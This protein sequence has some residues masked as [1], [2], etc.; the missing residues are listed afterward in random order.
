MEVFAEP[1]QFERRLQPVGLAIGVFDGVHR[2]HQALLGAMVQRARELQALPLVLTFDPHPNAVVRPDRNPPMI[3][4]L[5]QRLECLEA[6]GVEA[7][8]VAR[9]DRAFSLQQAEDFVRSLHGWFPQLRTLFVG[10]R[11]TFGHRRGGDTTLLRRLGG[12]LGFEVHPVQ[13]VQLE[14]A[15]VSS[16]RIRRLIQAGELA[17]AARLLGRPWR[18]AGQVERGEGIGRRMGVPTANVQAE[19]MVLPPLG[20]YAAKARWAEAWY[21][22][23]VNVGRRPTV[24]GTEAPVRV[25]AHLIG[26]EADLYG[27]QLE[28]EF[29]ERL[30]PERAFPSLEAL[31]QQI[32]KDLEAARARCAQVG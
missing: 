24:A 9:F 11:F 28:V 20:A 22:A 8:W 21:P 18:L 17:A 6:T 31:R 19:G 7:V 13:P 16:T 3:Q 30:R 1:A 12:Q 26:I 32:A 2:G 27:R 23:A 29:L 25:E 15:V 4:R 14:G 10:A 5:N